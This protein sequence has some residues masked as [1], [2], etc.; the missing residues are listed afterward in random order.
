MEYH[1]ELSGTRLKVVHSAQAHEAD[2]EVG[3]IIDH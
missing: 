3:D 1:A 2:T